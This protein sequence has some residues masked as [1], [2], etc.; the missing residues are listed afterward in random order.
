MFSIRI[1][2]LTKRFGGLVVID[3]VTLEV[4]EGQRRAIIGPNG[5]GKTTFF[6]LVSGQLAPTEGQIEI[7]G[8]DVARLSTAQR[9]R[10]G[11]RRTYQS[12][13][14][15]DEMTVIENL[16]IGL[17]GP[18]GRTHHLVVPWGSDGQTQQAA[19]DMTD[20]V[21]LTA[22]RATLAGDLSHGE[23]RQLELGMALMGQPRILLLDEP[24]AGLS[25]AERTILRRLLAEIPAE[26]TVLMIEH[27]MNIALSFAEEVTV[28]ANGAHILTGRPETVVADPRVQEVYLGGAA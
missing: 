25:I 9:A 2:N 21:G 3:G 8:R 18:L 1:T 26:V 11:V 23:R 28:L 5:A 7:L 16:V 14:L 6:N 22:R 15:F 4:P 13:S 24:A 19:R 12:S 10:M 17:L 20:R 27:D